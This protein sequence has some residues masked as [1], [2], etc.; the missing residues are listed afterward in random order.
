MT[1]RWPSSRRAS[2]SGRL[3]VTWMDVPPSAL[4]SCQTVLMSETWQETVTRS[5]AWSTRSFCGMGKSG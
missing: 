1:W 5:L 3:T 2:C 4:A